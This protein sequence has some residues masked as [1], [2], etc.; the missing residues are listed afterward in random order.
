MNIVVNSKFGTASLEEFV[1][2]ALKASK[3][4]RN[5]DGNISSSEIFS[6]IGELAPQ[7]FTFGDVIDEVRDLDSS[8][9]NHLCNVAA[10]NLP[11]YPNARAEAETFVVAVLQWVGQSVLLLNAYKQ[12]TKKEVPAAPAAG[13]ATKG[14]TPTNP[15]DGNKAVAAEG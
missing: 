11:D 15:K 3:L 2:A 8:E 4:D 7:F 1:V 10:A 6:A 13:G 5:A 14:K 12:M 9:I